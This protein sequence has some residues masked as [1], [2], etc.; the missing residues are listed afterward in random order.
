M[1]I[2]DNMMNR[3]FCY[4]CCFSTR[5]VS[6]LLRHYNQEHAHKP[7]F[8]ICC[9]IEGC[10]SSYDTVSSFRKHIYRK[11]KYSKVLTNSSNKSIVIEEELNSSPVD[12]QLQDE[13][14]CTSTSEDNS[15]TRFILNMREEKGLT[16]KAMASIIEEYSSNII[17]RC[18][19]STSSIVHSK[20]V[21]SDKDKEDILNPMK[22]LLKEHE[23]ANTVHKQRKLFREKGYIAPVEI[24][25]GNNDSVMYVSLL[26][27]LKRL[28]TH[29]DVLSHVLN[30]DKT[31][32][33]YDSFTSSDKF[34]K[35]KLFSSNPKALQIQL[36]VDD[37]QIVNPLGNKT[38]IHKICAFYWVLG[39][40]PVHLQSKLYT[41]QLAI[42]TE[43]RNV[44]KYG[45]EQVMSS[46]IADLKTLEEVGVSVVV[47]GISLNFF[48]TVSIFI[49][50]NLACHEVGGYLESFS[51]YKSC[52]FCN[53]TKESRSASF[54]EKDFELATPESY[55][56]KIASL[57]FNPN[58]ASAYGLKRNSELNKLGYFHVCWGC[59]SD[60]AH[61][62]YEGFALDLVK[63][64]IE[65]CLTKKYFSV[66][67]LNEK[68][69]DFP[70][71]A[72]D[73][74][75]KPAVVIKE[76]AVK[77]TIKQTAAQSLCLLKMLP[78]FVGN[79]IPSDAAHWIL[80]CDFLDALDYIVAPSLNK[81]EIKFM[82]SLISEFL[83]KFFQSYPSLPVK[84]K[85]HFLVHLATQYKMFG[86]PIHR[87]T[88]RFEGK[89][90]YFKSVIARS[91]NYINCCK[92][93]AERHQH[94]Q[95]LHHLS[96][97]YLNDEVATFSKQSKQVPVALLDH[98]I[99]NAVSEVTGINVN[100]NLCSSVKYNGIT[101]KS[102]MALVIDNVNDYEFGE[103]HKVTSVGGSVYCIIKLLSIDH[104][105][106]H[107]HSYIVSKTDQILFLK[108]SS[109]LSPFPLSLYE[110]GDG[111]YFLP[112]K[113]YIPQRQI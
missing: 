73:F 96:S 49:A 4:L 23:E 31:N 80:Y 24:K 30:T 52:R 60:I 48:G 95:C 109:L 105:S 91:K 38:K 37:F 36:Y 42:L 98:S 83:E 12:F 69:V 77:V 66:E 82:E 58:L 101:Y 88:L 78:L 54:Y 75:N 11:H 89:H 57:K 8:L 35:N 55:D 86:A 51:S 45:F 110:S 32:N 85:A 59:P 111:K 29:E 25:L 62:I 64:T 81:G 20:H 112:L 34:K 104:F 74:K 113:H 16:E 40:L 21:L 43:N 76:S 65:M 19:E 17:N 100:I 53:A 5:F 6:L 87:T 39:N 44:K 70:Y 26:D 61:D 93:M 56:A 103:I 108:L 107:Y 84:P 14:P 92:T 13:L 7:N 72:I 94:L 67:Y 63:A 47:N 3:I 41:I 50:D 22:T 28:L 97:S 68:I 99:A 27:T 71:S 90:S 18:I 15:L 9:G 79:K 46:L 1:L 106:C 2:Y 33:P 102:K 10:L